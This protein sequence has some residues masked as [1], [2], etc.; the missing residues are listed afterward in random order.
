[1]S[2][3]LCTACWIPKAT[4]TNS[5]YVILLSHCNSG[6]TNASQCYVLRTLPVL[7]ILLLYF[8]IPVCYTLPV[9]ASKFM[10]AYMWA[11]ARARARTHT[12]TH[13]HTHVLSFY[14][15]Y[16][17]KPCVLLCFSFVQVG[18]SRLVSVYPKHTFGGLSQED[19]AYS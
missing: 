18:V 16:Q 19:A 5:E 15:Q 14:C 7:F 1:M 8:S 17:Y 11:G 4:N 9:S 10:Y 3:E 12:H 13:T 6:C 2:N